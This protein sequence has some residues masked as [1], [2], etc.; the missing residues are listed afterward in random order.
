MS[1]D[2]KCFICKVDIMT[3]DYNHNPSGR[4]NLFTQVYVVL[5]KNTLNEDDE[6]VSY[7]ESRMKVPVC[8][9]CAESVTAN[10]IFDRALLQAEP[11]AVQYQENG[12]TPYVIERIR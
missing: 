9:T 11:N 4:N 5:R 6:V 8:K 2:G 12:F 3:F 7:V 10:Q 1:F